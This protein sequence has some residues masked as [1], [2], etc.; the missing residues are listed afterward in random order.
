[1]KSCLSY[2][3]KS[4]ANKKVMSQNIIL[5]TGTYDLIKDHVRR[6]KVKLHDVRTGII[7][8][9]GRKTYRKNGITINFS[10]NAVVLID[11]RN[12]IAGNRIFGPIAS[13][14]INNKYNKIIFLAPSVI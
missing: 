5:T 11:K 10:D 13:E 12:D 4:E 6:K 14:L 8:R 7:V 3:M 1:M 2:A 9:M